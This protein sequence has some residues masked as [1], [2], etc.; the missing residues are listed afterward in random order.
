[1]YLKSSLA[2]TVATIS[3]LLVPLGTEVQAHHAEDSR[4]EIEVTQKK[5]SSLND[6]Y[7]MYFM[8]EDGEGA[9]GGEGEEHCEGDESSEG[10]EHCEE[11]H[12]EEEGDG[13][14]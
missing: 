12:T 9:E 2:L 4:I 3:G 8:G 7:S 14:G 10:E 11:E 6:R 5:V 1:M 13:D